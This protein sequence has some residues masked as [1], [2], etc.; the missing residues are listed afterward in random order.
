MAS[1]AVW[2]NVGGKA[3]SISFGTNGGTPLPIRLG[4]P[5]DW[6]G[7]LGWPSPLATNAASFVSYA[8]APRLCSGSVRPAW[9]SHLGDETPR[10]GLPDPARWLGRRA[11]PLTRLRRVHADNVDADPNFVTRCPTYRRERAEMELSFRFDHLTL[12]VRPRR[13]GLE[14]G[15]GPWK[16]GPSLVMSKGVPWEW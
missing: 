12:D 3:L 15:E 7:I 1:L 9:P 4:T 16:Q 11:V 13:S 14:V 5:G 10:G 8:T 6:V 2:V